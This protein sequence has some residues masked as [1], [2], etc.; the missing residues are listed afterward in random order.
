MT[1]TRSSSSNAD[2]ATGE[3]SPGADV[4]VRMQMWQLWAESLCRCGRGEPG[5]DAGV[6]M[7]EPGPDADVGEEARSWVQMW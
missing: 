6:E 5:P 3:P 2:V 1:V 7:H 4:V